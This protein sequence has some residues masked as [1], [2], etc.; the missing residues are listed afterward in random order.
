MERKHLVI[1]MCFSKAR[2]PAGMTVQSCS[3]ALGSALTQL[4]NNSRDPWH[5]L[6]AE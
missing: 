6:F 3:T 4:S 1:D 5:H 2:G